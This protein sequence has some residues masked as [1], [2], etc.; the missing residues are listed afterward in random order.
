MLLYTSFTYRS[1]YSH[2]FC[3]S[4]A[5]ICQHAWSA[6]LKTELLL[7]F[8]WACMAKWLTLRIPD[9]EVRDSSLARRIVSL[10]QGTLFHFVS[11]HPGV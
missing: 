1:Y 5:I 9:L 3:N 8:V 2:L 11:L 10:R 4:I 6:P 7:H